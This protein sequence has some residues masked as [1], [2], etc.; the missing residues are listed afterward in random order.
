[1][2][3]ATVTEFFFTEVQLVLRYN[4]KNCQ[5][6]DALVI[7]TW[8]VVFKC[9]LE[10]ERGYP[11]VAGGVLGNQYGKLIVILTLRWKHIGH[12]NVFVK[13]KG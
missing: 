13:Q 2:P 9:Y 11:N 4:N 5:R 1:M 12:Y 10:G 7:N 3:T 8:S 6:K